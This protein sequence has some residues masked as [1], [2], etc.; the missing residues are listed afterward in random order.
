MSD[1]S[2]GRHLL[3]ADTG[4]SFSLQHLEH[5][6]AD[7]DFADL[8]PCQPQTD[9]EKIETLLDVLSSG[10][11]NDPD[12]DLVRDLALQ[13]LLTFP[14]LPERTIDIMR[15]ILADMDDSDLVLNRKLAACDVLTHIGQQA[16]E[17]DGE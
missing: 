7:D 2:Q 16:I 9:E 3:S 11:V 6:M 15:S 14:R 12:L 5:K 1:L 4:A 13:H 17:A 10:F 8:K